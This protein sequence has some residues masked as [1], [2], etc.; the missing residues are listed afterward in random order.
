MLDLIN[1]VRVTV[2]KEKAARVPHF[3]DEAI[4]EIDAS[5]TETLGECKREAEPSLG[6]IR[7]I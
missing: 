1:D 6:A 2:W 5:L 3:F 7:D 4:L